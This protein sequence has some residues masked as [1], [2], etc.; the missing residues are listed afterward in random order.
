MD[1]KVRFG[2]VGCGV[3]GPTHAKAI[4]G[5]PNA[6]IVAVADVVES[7][8]QKL[9]GDY[10]CDWYGSLEELANRPDIDIVTLGVPSG[11]HAEL[12]EKAL[13]AGKHVVV[14]KPLDVSIEKID[15][16][17]RTQKET[18]GK[19]AVISQHR[20]D[21]ATQIVHDAVERG[22]FGKLTLGVA[23]LIWWRSQEYYDSGDWRGTWALDGGGALM[24]QSIHTID[25]LQ[26]MMGP[27]EEIFAY[28]GLLAHERIEV[29]DVAVATLKFQS[30]ALG[31]I[32]GTTAAYPGLT[33]RL[34]IHGDKGSAVIDNDQ[35]QYFHSAAPGEGGAA[36]G[37][38]G[39][40]NQAEQI[41][42]NF[43]AQ[44]STANAASD[45]SQLSMAHRDQIED[46]I[47]AIREGREPLVNGIEGRKAVAIILGIYESARTGKPV[48]PA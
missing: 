10:G 26:W 32:I 6:E 18:G 8:A 23:S 36:Y 43:K 4:A 42:A 28:T 2:I 12:A 30:G 15:S 1:S 17:L 16:L 29:E 39:K 27:V 14:E 9:A 31:S 24:N 13:R 11:M 34:Q 40:G 38:S 19:V 21:T 22:E 25:L 41:L 20:F 48:R 44:E 35:L 47:A 45:P 7:K 5:I 33:A 46:F 37:A 3:I